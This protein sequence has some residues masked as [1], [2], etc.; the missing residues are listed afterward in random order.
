MG[1]TCWYRGHPIQSAEASMIIGEYQRYKNLAKLGIQTNQSD[2]SV[3]MADC[4]NLISNELNR[5]R[6]ASSK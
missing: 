1:V 5:L 4:F 3:F 6:S 2:I